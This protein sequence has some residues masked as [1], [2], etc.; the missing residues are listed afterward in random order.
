MEYFDIY[1]INRQKTDRKGVRGEKTPE[2]DMRLV[3][4]I[5]I[6]NKKGEMLIQ[7]RQ[8]FKKGWSGLW[9]IS[10]GGSAIAGDDSRR[11]A[12]REVKEELSLDLQITHRPNFNINFDGGFDDFYLVDWD[13]D[14]SAL[15][16]QYSEVE[17]VKWATRQEILSMILDGS[18]VP[19]YPSLINMIF[20]MKN[21]MVKYGAHFRE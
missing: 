9:D 13:G 3:V 19:Y 12:E 16:L 18:F 2:G 11:A 20:D 8:P 1:D 21:S 10:V 4:H 15:Q 17:S 14:I 5:C 6:V 7:H